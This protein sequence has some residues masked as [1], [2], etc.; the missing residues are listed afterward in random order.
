MAL[1]QRVDPPGTSKALRLWQLGGSR[2]TEYFHLGGMVWQSFF[3]L[4]KT[5]SVLRLL[6]RELKCRHPS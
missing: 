2:P 4:M 3:S 5:E 1:G 6:L